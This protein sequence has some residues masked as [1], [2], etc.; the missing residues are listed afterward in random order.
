MPGSIWLS[1]S[2]S[3]TR[4]LGNDGYRPGPTAAMNWP[5]DCISTR[6]RTSG[7]S[8]VSLQAAAASA[9]AWSARVRADGSLISA[10]HKGSIHSVAAQ[11]QGAPACN[12]WAFWHV[13]R[14]GELV[15]I[16]R[17]RQQLRGELG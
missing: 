10:E 13:E 3:A 2:P 17:L 7:A 11:L 15:L 9:Q 12:G 6:A 8:E 16:D 4:N 1:G 5:W 14:K